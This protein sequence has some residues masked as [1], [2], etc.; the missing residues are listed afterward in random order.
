[1][2]EFN[3]IGLRSYQEED[4]YRFKGR[5]TETKELL[6]QVLRNAYTVCYAESG[7]GK[8]SLID[9][10]VC[11][12][13]RRE[14]FMPVHIR[15]NKD[16]YKQVPD[17][18]QLFENRLLGDMAEYAKRHGI[19]IK[20]ELSTKDFEGKIYQESLRKKLS[21]NPWWR[22][23]NYKFYALGLTFTPVYIFDQFEEVFNRP[24]SIEWTDVFFNWLKEIS[25]DACP[26]SVVE[27]TRNVIGSKAPF[28]MIECK[29][30]FK[31]LFSLRSEFIGDLDYWGVQRNNIYE[32]KDNRYC[33][34]ALT[35]DSADKILALSDFSNEIKDQIKRN[36]NT[37]NG[38]RIQNMNLP[39][40]SAFMLSM[41]CTSIEQKEG[42]GIFHGIDC[43][44]SDYYDTIILKVKQETRMP[45]KHLD[46]IEQKL[47]DN[48]GHKVW[49][50]AD[51]GELGS[52]KFT[53]RYLDALKEKRIIN[54][55]N[56]GNDTYV[57][58]VH[59]RLADV[60]KDRLNSR[61]DRTRSRW[62]TLT[63]GV[64]I[65]LIFVF[66]IYKFAFSDNRNRVFSDLTE[67]TDLYLT[68]NDTAFFKGDNRGR[69]SNNTMVENLVIN[70]TTSFQISSCTFLKKIDV[71][72]EDTVF[73]IDVQDCP[74]LKEMTFSNKVRQLKLGNVLKCPNLEIVLG[75]SIDTVIVEP[76]EALPIE[77]AFRVEDNPRFI[78]EKAYDNQTNEDVLKH[79]LWDVKAQSVLYAQC[80]VPSSFTFPLK[81]K[82]K[83]A[84]WESAYPSYAKEYI[85][86]TSV[87]QRRRDAMLV[88][89]TLWQ[90]PIREYRGE[91]DVVVLTDSIKTISAQAFRECKNLKKIVLSNTLQEIG[92]QAFYGLP[93]LDT[94][95]IPREV[96]RIGK[97]AFANCQSLR[98]VI[99]KSMQDLELGDRA[100][101][102]CRQLQ[103]VE[104]PDRVN[105]FC[106]YYSNNP[107]FRCDNIKN[108]TGLQRENSIF[109]KDGDVIVEKE[110]KWPFVVLPTI[111][112]YQGEAG[113]I[114]D[115]VFKWDGQI[116]HLT[117]EGYRHISDESNG[118]RIGDEH[119][120]I[121]Y[122]GRII[123]NS[124][125]IIE[126]LTIPITMPKAQWDFLVQPSLLQDIY[127]PYPQPESA[128]S[129][130]GL[131]FNLS[132]AVKQH[133]TLHVPFGC[134]KYY[135]NHPDFRDF[136]DVKEE[137]RWRTYGNLL[138]LYYKKVVSRI[139]L[140]WSL[141]L[142]A[143][144][145]L[146]VCYVLNRW[147]KISVFKS[148]WWATWSFV[149]LY[150]LFY[151]LY[152]V[153]ELNFVRHGLVLMTDLILT[154]ISSI[155]VP[156]MVLW[157]KDDISAW[158][159]VWAESFKNQGKA[160]GHVSLNQIVKDKGY[161]LL[162]WLKQRWFAILVCV[163]AIWGCKVLYSWWKEY[164]NVDIMV[165]KG[166]FKRAIELTY[167]QLMISDSLSLEQKESLG[168]LLSRATSL[169]DYGDQKII[170]GIQGV[171]VGGN[172]YIHLYQ[173]GRT[174]IY[175]P[176]EIKQYEF[177]DSV[178]FIPDIMGKYATISH[179]DTTFVVMADNLYQQVYQTVDRNII[180]VFD[181]Y[182]VK[183]ENGESLL[184]DMDTAMQLYMTVK[185]KL[186]NLD[187][188]HSLFISEDEDRGI[189][190]LTRPIN[191]QFVTDSLPGRGMRLEL[192]N[193]LLDKEIFERIYNEAKHVNAKVWKMT[194]N[195]VVL[196]NDSA[197]V[198]W[199]KWVDNF[200]PIDQSSGNSYAQYD[201]IGLTDDGS[202][203][204]IVAYNK[205][206]TL[207]LYGSGSSTSSITSGT[208]YDVAFKGGMELISNLYDSNFQVEVTPLS[209]TWVSM[210]KTLKLR[211]VYSLNNVYV[212]NG[213]IYAFSPEKM[214]LEVHNLQ[215][216]QDM[217]RTSK[218]LTQEQKAKLVEKCK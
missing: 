139:R 194:D 105:A 192:G 135:E 57:Q 166:N 61:K 12:D 97:E 126:E 15:F 151:L 27:A 37:D 69:L 148:W 22:I 159:S 118:K 185:G 115:G 28:P 32:L 17:M 171:S 124:D 179:Q 131:A 103:E 87:N 137:A 212:V 122:I 41:M 158:M 199:E 65:A 95:L 188:D 165:S 213:W 1:M 111:T 50:K 102:N 215:S 74:M 83:K 153:Y 81:I 99:L 44:V 77:V 156:I 92:D 174:I 53:E 127:V 143:L 21:E 154:T 200:T 42:N 134:K 90:N 149:S 163:L 121:D 101:A 214:E 46:I 117:K 190:Y 164:N 93:L 208:Y 104:M 3:Y 38:I 98:K 96:K 157:F 48:Q 59:D 106:Y 175:D 119:F 73:F 68:S 206:S 82:A 23:R 196:Y 136:K 58:F 10:G 217:I 110:K 178:L 216:V 20:Y 120:M 8:S 63:W 207:V 91:A 150:T 205:T 109:Q 60:V 113:E 161:R 210:G 34:K 94:V 107:F 76:N 56:F 9:A 29:K 6:T 155:A 141:A 182:I 66:S 78:W 116:I 211:N 31:M 162:N 88:V 195:H 35:L 89:D 52:I 144:V 202:N 13:L 72:I 198:Y 184:Y 180:G 130:E 189:T 25:D 169:P 173:N 7:E 100:F 86:N 5:D 16:D 55:R 62:W 197:K 2:K 147:K 112:S 191:A 30:S 47:L 133:I 24:L 4:A 11:P 49:V 67:Y 203:S 114:K 75:P 193:R 183:Y 201:Y 168:N 177:N 125:S 123:L 140:W 152:V 218:Y 209:K 71:D 186:V 33:L 176:H 108:F 160:G 181:H 26:M 167:R 204:C 146:V 170:E 84:Y 80:N 132:T 36:L 18:H 145:V 70:D 79:V 172:R 85:N 138:S 64:A 129:D 128:D 51:S 19:E 45:Q 43:I 40:I 54:Q 142:Y 187:P 39:C 14:N